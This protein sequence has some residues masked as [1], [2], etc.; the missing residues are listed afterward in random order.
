MKVT[1]A[2]E[3][4]L[5]A[6]IAMWEKLSNWHRPFNDYLE[7]AS[8][9]RE[10][11]MESFKKDLN[12]NGRLLLIAKERKYNIG[13]IRGEIRNTNEMFHQKSVGYI[14]DLFVEEFY[15]GHSVSDNLVGEAICWF[16]G[17]GIDY[18]RLNVNSQ[19]INAIRFYNRVG[20]KEVNKT[21]SLKISNN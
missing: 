14:S 4:D 6:I 8:D 10:Y 11:L 5:P 13:F 16:K 18:I 7:P 19:N 20:F 17:L 12:N 1:R 21:L 3:R 9:W 15:R 2:R